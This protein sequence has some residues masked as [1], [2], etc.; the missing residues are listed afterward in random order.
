[1]TGP[2]M[3]FLFVP[4]FR[5]E[6]S[7]TAS[8]LVDGSVTSPFR[9]EFHSFRAILFQD[10]TRLSFGARA[11]AVHYRLFSVWTLVPVRLDI[12]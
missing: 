11:V 10:N 4:V 9:N 6:Q 7:M 12:Q 1:M 3:E 2:N 5:R 8:Q